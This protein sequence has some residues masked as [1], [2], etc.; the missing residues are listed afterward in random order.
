MIKND[1]VVAYKSIE[2]LLESEGLDIMYPSELP[3][4]VQIT[5]ISEQIISPNYTIYCYK[6]SDENIS[7]TVSTKSNVVL[8]NMEKH[9]K[10]E[11]THIVAYLV[12]NEMGD[13]Q[14]ICYDDKYEYRICCTDYDVLIKL[15]SL[16]GIE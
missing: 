5:K 15:L 8:E 4:G 2:E 11:N 7:I 16:R 12:K 3:E 6:F 14:A 13:C 10:I 1:G 9:P